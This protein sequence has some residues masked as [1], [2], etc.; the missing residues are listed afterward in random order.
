MLKRDNDEKDGDAAAA[1]AAAPWTTCGDDGISIGSDSSGSD[2]SGSDSSCII[3]RFLQVCRDS[4]ITAALATL[5]F[6]RRLPFLGPVLPRSAS[7]ADATDGMLEAEEEARPPSIK[8][9]ITALWALL[10]KTGMLHEECSVT[11]VFTAVCLASSTANFDFIVGAAWWSGGGGGGGVDDD[12][13][14][15]DDDG[16]GD[17]DDYDYDDDDDDDDDDDE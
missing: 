15:D 16:D 17:G 1:S 2:S 11:A 14:D 13:D 6:N 7:V 8:G 12:N 5:D 10:A 3:D 4:R 9:T